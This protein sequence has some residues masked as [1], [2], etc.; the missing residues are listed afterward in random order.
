MNDSTQLETIYQFT[1]ASN[2]RNW[3][4][5]NDTV[6]GGV[7]YGHIKINEEGNGVFTGKV[8]LKNNGGFCSV[9]YPVPRKQIGKFHNFVLKVCGDGKEYQFR[10]KE[11]TED[12][13]VYKSVFKTTKQW[14][15]IKIPFKEMFPSF[16]GRKLN[17]SNFSGQ[18]LEEIAFLPIMKK[19]ILSYQLVVLN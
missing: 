5:I 3:H 12:A 7:S 9:R 6:M 15:E 14:Q 1:A 13:H 11:N 10:I 16:R 4:T 2:L 17:K 18:S 19:N 8:S